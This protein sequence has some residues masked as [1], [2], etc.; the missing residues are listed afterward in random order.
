M[1]ATVMIAILVGLLVVTGSPKKA[2]Q[3]SG[4]WGCV[5]REP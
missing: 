4:D 3:S 5:C 2:S 1:Q